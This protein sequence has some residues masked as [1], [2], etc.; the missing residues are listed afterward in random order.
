MVNTAY[1]TARE[2]PAA[3]PWAAVGVSAFDELLYQAI[4][5]QPDAGAA[6]WALLT[7]A[8]PAR[9]REACN[10]LLTLGLLQPPDSMGGLRAVDPRVAIRALIRRR[11]TESELLAATAEEMATAYEAGLLREEPSRLVE[12]ASGEG[13]IAA[14]LEEMYA[15]AEHEVCLFDTPPYLAPPAPQ[16]DLQADL[17]SRGIV[18]RGIYAATGLEDPKVLSRALSMVELGEQARVLPIVPLKL[19]VVDGC[20]ALL[21]LT[22]SAAGGYCA[23]VVWHSAVTEALQK[24]FELAW[25]QAT[26]LG[27]P[28]SDGELTEDERTLTRLL[29]AGMKDEAVARHLGV[30][31]RTLRRRVSDLQERLGAA[32]RFQL[33]MRAAQRGWV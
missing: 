24:L 8:S 7:G 20:R 33:G 27:Q 2:T 21:P 23:V 15:R 16:V 10:R 9:V 1:D 19:L 18:S 30:S 3:S 25:Q 26:P 28:V 6:G 12:V 31:L 5:N 11:E 4:L 13:A 29:A 22:A 14:R 32:S 17:L